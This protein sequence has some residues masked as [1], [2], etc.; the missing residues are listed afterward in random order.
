MK[1][2]FRGLRSFF[3]D[4]AAQALIGVTLTLVGIGTVFYRIVEDLSWI[5][6]VYFTFITLTTVGYGDISPQTVPGKLFTMGYVVIGIG[7]LVA[8]I[9]E[10][11]RHLI[12]EQS[13]N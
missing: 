3:R 10:I 13:T 8:F 9:T 1:H 2:L 7:V 6:S 4:P 11:A 5:D 12:D